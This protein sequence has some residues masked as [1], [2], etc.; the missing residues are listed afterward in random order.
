MSENIK[1]SHVCSLCGSIMIPMKKAK[2]NFLTEL[3]LWIVCLVLAMF[4]AGISLA[5]ALV[6]SLWRMISGRK[7]CPK[8]DSETFVGVDT[9]MGKKIIKDMGFVPS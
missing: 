3:I 7:V 5:F 8:C 9:P 4:T 2:S 1:G 6:F